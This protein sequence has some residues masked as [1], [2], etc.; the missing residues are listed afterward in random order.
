MMITEQRDWRAMDQLHQYHSN[1]YY[2]PFSHYYSNLVQCK[3]FQLVT[4]VSKQKRSSFFKI[5]IKHLL[6][7]YHS[8]SKLN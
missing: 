1:A 6:F 8:I 2:L 5:Y 7:L 3:F 4:L